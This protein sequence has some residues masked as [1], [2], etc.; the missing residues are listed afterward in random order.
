MKKLLL[1]DVDG[2]LIQSDAIKFDYWNAIVKKHFNLEVSRESVYRHGKTDRQ[3]LFELIQFAGIKDPEKDRRFLEAL[4]DL[5]RIV[6]EAM[7][8]EKIKK[9]LGV[10]KFVQLIVKKDVKIGLLTG[11]TYKKAK[12]KLI[13]CGLWKYFKIG[14]FGDAT[15]IRSEL[16]PIALND[17]KEKFKINFDRADVYLVGDTVRDIRCAREAGVKII[18]VA[19]GKETVDQLKREKPDHVFK[20]FS[21]PSKIIGSIF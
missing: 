7:K 5:E 4:N 14:A 2:I 3:I 1:F 10:E 17:A 21:D 9:V 12:V 13:G 8:K 16:I 20:D 15:K 18:A 6:R 19:T 11:N